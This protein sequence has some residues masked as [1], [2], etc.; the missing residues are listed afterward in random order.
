[1]DQI[2]ELKGRSARGTPSV[3]VSVLQRA[4]LG[5]VRKLRRHRFVHGERLVSKAEQFGLRL[6]DRWQLASD[7]AGAGP[8]LEFA[9]VV[10]RA[11]R[12]DGAEPWVAM[13]H[14]LGADV[15]PEQARLALARER[16]DEAML[17]LRDRDDAIAKSLLVDAIQRRDGEATA[18][19]YYEDNFQ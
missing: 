13:A 3:D 5:E 12:P 10:T 7:G 9:V 19:Q 6:K 2:S 15:V 18:L 17:L 16:P 4:V 14:D 1:S 8:C 11:G